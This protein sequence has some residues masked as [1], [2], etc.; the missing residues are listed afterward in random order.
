MDLDGIENTL[1]K[2]GELYTENLDDYGFGSKSVGWRD[3]ESHYMRFEKLAQILTPGGG[4]WV[5]RNV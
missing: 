4:V 1:Q 2:V 5:W 3:E